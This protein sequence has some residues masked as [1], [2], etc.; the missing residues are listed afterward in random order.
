[1]YMCIL[2]TDTVIMHA[3]FRVWV[4][5]KLTISVQICTD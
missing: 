5:M 4:H 3:Y 2:Y 1:M